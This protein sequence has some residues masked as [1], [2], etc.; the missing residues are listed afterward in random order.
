MGTSFFFKAWMKS[1]EFEDV[2]IRVHRNALVSKRH[3][4]ELVKDREGQT[5]VQLQDVEGIVS[6]S[7]R[8]LPSVRKAIKKL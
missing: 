8:H 7:R 2:F 4:E 6:V 3:I 5:G 1:S